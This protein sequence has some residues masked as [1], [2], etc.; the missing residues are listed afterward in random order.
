M[1]HSTKRFVFE[2]VAAFISTAL[3]ILAITFFF[4]K[5]IPGSPFSDEGG[6]S[7]VAISSLEK[8]YGYDQ[9]LL[10]QFFSYIM[11]LLQGN[12][13][14]SLI[15]RE[16]DVGEILLNALPITLKL[17]AVTLVISLS[18]GTLIGIYLAKTAKRVTWLKFSLIA[19]LSLPS[20][21]IAALLQDLVAD[22]LSL[23]LLL[24]ALSL[25]FAPTATIARFTSDRLQKVLKEPYIQSA[26]LKG[27]TERRILLMHALPSALTPT[28]NYLAQLASH[29]IMGSF[30]VEKLFALHGVGSITTV[31]V[32]NRDYPVVLASGLFYTLTLLFFI[33]LSDL[34]YGFIDPRLRPSSE[35]EA[36]ILN[37]F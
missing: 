3:L 13:G 37:P 7:R 18:I 23:P 12:F 29:L 9:S 4:M 34:I 10:S 5:I 24:P 20:F 6:I 1:S 30:A 25:S 2:T 16:R 31:A 36:P 19:A 32:L 27:L 8:S 22:P 26:T 14:T 21:F 11:E 33:I 28:V 15:Y 35:E 17:T